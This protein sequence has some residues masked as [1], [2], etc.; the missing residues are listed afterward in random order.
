MTNAEVDTRTVG[1]GGLVL[2]ALYRVIRERMENPVEKS[3]TT[4]LMQKGIDT[5]LKKVGEEATELVIAGKGG[6]R[7]EIVHETADLMYHMF[8]LLGFNDI[9]PEDVYAELRRRFGISGITEKESR[10]S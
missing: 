3:Y 7:S 8:V 9:M 2:D 6:N 5:I 10:G 4:S 1:D